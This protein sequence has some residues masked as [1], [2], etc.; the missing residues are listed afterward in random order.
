M[1]EKEIITMKILPSTAFP[2][3]NTVG[4]KLNNINH[5]SSKGKFIISSLDKCSRKSAVSEDNTV[6]THEILCPGK[7]KNIS[8]NE[9]KIHQS[10]GS[11]HI[12]K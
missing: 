9:S 1:K 12:S 5:I 6:K 2:M 4:F 8:R 3:L 11:L 10:R 7:Q